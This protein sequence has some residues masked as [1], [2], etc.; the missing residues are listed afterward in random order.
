MTTI[1]KAEENIAAVPTMLLDARNIDLTEYVVLLAYQKCNL[2]ERCCKKYP[3][4]RKPG[5]L[6]KNKEKKIDID[7]AILW[8]TNVILQSF[9]AFQTKHYSVNAAVLLS[10]YLKVSINLTKCPDEE[11]EGRHIH[12]LVNNLS[13]KYSKSESELSLPLQVVGKKPFI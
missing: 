12:S 11:I 10:Q 7:V 3:T 9:S 1:C 5:S 8:V 4:Q 2:G 6:G 13:I